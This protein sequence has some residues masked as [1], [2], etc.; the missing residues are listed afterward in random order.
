MKII[1]AI[2]V[3]YAAVFAAHAVFLQKTVGV[4]FKIFNDTG[5]SG[6]TVSVINQTK[7]Q[8]L[9]GTPITVTNNVTGSYDNSVD[10][11]GIQ[12]TWTF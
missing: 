4:V 1:F 12:F 6:F 5:R 7:Q 9:T 8:A 3:L 2:L 11:I 10:I